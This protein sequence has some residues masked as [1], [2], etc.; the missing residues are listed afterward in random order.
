M[1]FNTKNNNPFYHFLNNTF[2]V[3]NL[4]F[5]NCL[6]NC[7]NDRIIKFYLSIVFNT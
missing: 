3:F 7:E 1:F 5:I 2:L 4:Y 6:F